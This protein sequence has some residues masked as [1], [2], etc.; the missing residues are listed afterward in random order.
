MPKNKRA[1]AGKKQTSSGRSQSGQHKR[2]GNGHTQ[3]GHM[4]QNLEEGFLAELAD[5]LHGERQILKFLPK[6]AESVSSR[7]LREAIEMHAEQTEDQVMRLERVFR[8][9]DRKPQVEVCE[10]LQGIIAEGR[11]ILHKTGQGPV[12]DAM[13]VAA[14]QKV[15]HYEIASYG[16]LCA[17]ADQL[18]ER[19]A[20]DLLE[21]TLI[22]EKTTDR[23]LSR[24][25]EGF[26]NQSADERRPRGDDEWRDR[27]GDWRGQGQGRGQGMQQAMGSRPGMPS[28]DRGFE[29]GSRGRGF[30]GGE[31]HEDEQRFNERERGRGGRERFDE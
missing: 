1:G 31:R 10:G 6:L 24:I 4:V 13:I 7:R 11:E 16:T 23:N 27:P 8:L 21:Q 20:L 29:E 2:A 30:E 3:G 12:R 19:E 18:E 26:A 14:A 28:R 5:M 15:E 9:F 22:E 17:W 25:A